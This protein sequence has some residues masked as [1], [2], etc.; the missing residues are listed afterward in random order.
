MATSNP[1]EPGGSSAGSFD[2]R[3][4]GAAGLLE[5]TFDDTGAQPSAAD[6]DKRPVGRPDLLTGHV[7]RHAEH[8]DRQAACQHDPSFHGHLPRADDTA[9]ATEPWY[10]GTMK[11][12]PTADEPSPASSPW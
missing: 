2:D 10:P 1:P 8:D 7:S 5:E 6:D 12:D 9:G 11:L 4:V 3:D